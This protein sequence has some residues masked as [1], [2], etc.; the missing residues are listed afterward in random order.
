MLK[1]YNYG[2]IIYSPLVNLINEVKDLEEINTLIIDL[3]YTDDISI[4][5]KYIN[6]EVI[7]NTYK[8]FFNTKTIYK[9]KDE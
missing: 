4:I 8:G 6:K 5:D 1:E 9:L 2:T 7:N 3:S